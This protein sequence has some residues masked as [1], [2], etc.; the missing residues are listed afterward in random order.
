VLPLELEQVVEQ[1]DQQRLALLGAEDPLEDEV[2]LGV[3]EDGEHGEVLRPAAAAG[4][5]PS[6]TAED[7]RA[8]GQEARENEPVVGSTTSPMAGKRQARRPLVRSAKG[9]AALFCPPLHFS[10]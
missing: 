10:K 7:V 8:L 9:A 6:R 1:R 5:G 2:G 3:G 4:N